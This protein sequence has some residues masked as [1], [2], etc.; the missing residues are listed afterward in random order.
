LFKL[1]GAGLNTRG[2]FSVLSG[3]LVGDE[4]VVTVSST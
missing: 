2:N 4:A 1:S 3:S